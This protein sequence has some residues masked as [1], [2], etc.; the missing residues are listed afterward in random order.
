LS[1]VGKF[2]GK[3]WINTQDWT[4]EQLSVLLRAS[5]D[6]KKKYRANRPH[7]YLKGKTLFMIFYNRSLRTR[8]SFEAGMHQ[9]GGHAHFLSPE[10]VYTPVLPG[11]D[12]AYSTERIADVARVLERYG[13]GIAIRI[14][15]KHAKYVYGRGNQVV[16]EFAKWAKIPVI[17]MECDMYHPCQAMAD[18]MAVKE[19]FNQLKGKKFVMSW[20]YTPSVEKPMAVPQSAV[21]IATQFGMDVVLAH[22]KGLELDPQVIKWCEENADRYGG[23]FATSNDMK[24]SFEGAHVVYPK[25]WWS[26]EMVP[27]KKSSPDFDGLKSLFDAN[28]SWICDQAKMDVADRKAI[29]MHCLPA[30]RG[31]EVTDDVIDGPQSV[32]FDE[33]ENRLHAQKAIM[34]MTM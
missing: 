28:K 12:V 18:I 13:Q 15:G 9:L 33:A 6:L 4:Q 32:V 14:Y 30:D 8:N 10:D 21:L 22:P 29:Y 25:S 19:K 7:Q 27:P 2:K 20:A 5:L 34:A 26:L 31:C 11:D 23:S 16:R 3:D 1:Y 24:S 17:N